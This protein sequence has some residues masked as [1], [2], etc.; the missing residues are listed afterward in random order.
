[1]L[2]MMAEK[3]FTIVADKINYVYLNLWTYSAVI[4]KVWIYR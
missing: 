4:H 1:M 2:K 3:I